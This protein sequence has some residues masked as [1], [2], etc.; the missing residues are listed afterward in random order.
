MPDLT[1][2]TNEN[3]S[4]KETCF[5]W[6]SEAKERNQ[7]YQKFEPT[8]DDGVD[9]KCDFMMVVNFKRKKV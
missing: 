4:L 9:F 6:S 7:S 8:K 1:K 2:C 5:R 3:C